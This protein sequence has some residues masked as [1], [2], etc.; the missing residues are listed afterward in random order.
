MG[1]PLDTKEGL[2]LLDLD[3]LLANGSG[4]FPPTPRRDNPSP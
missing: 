2:S 1:N 4:K 3:D